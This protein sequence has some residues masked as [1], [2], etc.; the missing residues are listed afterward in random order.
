MRTTLRIDDSLLAAAKS[1]AAQRRQTLGE[2]VNDLLRRALNAG[3][4]GRGGARTRNGVPVF[5]APH[6][7]RG[8]VTLEVVNALRDEEA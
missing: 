4:R 1:L 7:R 3:T 2:V 6:G 5:T 8:P